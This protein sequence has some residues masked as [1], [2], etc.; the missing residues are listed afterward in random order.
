MSFSGDMIT[1]VGPRKITPNEERVVYLIGRWLFSNGFGIRS[2]LA[3]GSDINF[4]NGYLSKAREEIV[5]FNKSDLN[6]K[7]EMYVPK[8]KDWQ[9]KPDAFTYCPPEE[10]IWEECLTIASDI[11]PNWEAC[12]DYARRLHGRNIPQVL[13]RDL[14]SPSKALVT[15]VKEISTGR[16]LGG[17]NTAYN[18]AYKRNIAIINVYNEVFNKDRNAIIDKLN[19]LL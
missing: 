16:R 19:T 4:Y 15:C 9:R 12:D 5:K 3:V 13:G 17:T 11:H 6:G 8:F 14:K 18:L 7:V 10:V 2:G 1:C